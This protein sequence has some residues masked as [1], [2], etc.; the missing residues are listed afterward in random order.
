MKTCCC[1]ITYCCVSSDETIF[2]NINIYMLICQ[3][4]VRKILW[5]I[6]HL[7]TFAVLYSWIYNERFVTSL[8]GLPMDRSS[9]GALKEDHNEC[10]I[11]CNPTFYLRINMAHNCNRK[12]MRN[13]GT[14][15]AAQVKCRNDYDSTRSPCSPQI[16]VC[17]RPNYHVG[18]NSRHIPSEPQLKFC[19]TITNEINDP[20]LP[21]IPA[22]SIDDTMFLK[23]PTHP[24]A[25]WWELSS[26]KTSIHPS[27][28]SKS[29]AKSSP[30]VKSNRCPSA[31]Q[32]FQSKLHHTIGKSSS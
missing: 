22:K 1:R 32:P 4:F 12:M 13:D 31:T 29:M 7:I 26:A 15:Q 10:A 25:T 16:C 20:R 14:E 19:E 9:N 23:R 24:Y 30:P 6:K 8:F 27:P 21:A 3:K 11:L 18:T 28:W 2:Q 17:S 5:N